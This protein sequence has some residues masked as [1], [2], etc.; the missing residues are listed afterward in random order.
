MEASLDVAF[1]K[2]SSPN[3]TRLGSFY[4]GERIMMSSLP[5]SQDE[6]S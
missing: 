2:S 4:D 1:C 5:P 3:E 6:P